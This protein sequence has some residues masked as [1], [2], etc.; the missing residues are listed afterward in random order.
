M[1]LFKQPKTVNYINRTLRL[2]ISFVF[3]LAD[4]AINLVRRL[5]GRSSRDACVVLYYHGVTDAQRPRFRRQMEWLKSKTQVVSVAEAVSAQGSGWRT[6]ITFD[7]ALDNVQRNV[8]PILQ[9]LGLPATIFA[10]S[11]NLGR[12]PSW[13]M[14][15]DHPDIEERVM[16]ADQVLAL[17]REL[18]EIGSH[19]V[20]HLNLTT[21]PSGQVRREL[22]DSKRQLEAIL[23]TPVVAFSAPFG[24]CTDEMLQLAREVGYKIAL[25]CE[26]EVI[27][28]GSESLGIGRFRA[29]PG[30]WT[31]EFRL[32]AAG[33][34]RWRRY[35]RRLMRSCA[36]ATGGAPT[37]GY[38]DV[39]SRAEGASNARCS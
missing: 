28:R 13:E 37:T 34:Y 24:E 5:L 35:A 29:S 18:I 31:L 30:D 4:R 20:N 33:A 26:P 10:V 11:G 25:T 22:V 2:V 3:W 27:D 8:V 17:P 9:E 1:Y 23:G 12:R 16:S 39:K 32:K 19:T 21:L 36:A 7:D 14:A 6:C 15:P 38:G